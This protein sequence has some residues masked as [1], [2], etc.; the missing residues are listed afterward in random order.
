MGKG[1]HS[2]GYVSLHRSIL[3]WGWYQ[4]ANTCRL[5]IHLLLTAEYQDRSVH[6]RTI[7]RGQRLCSVETLAVELGLSNRQTR[8][9]LEHLKST[10]EVTSR[11]SPQG[12]VITVKNYVDYQTP[13]ND[14][15]NDRQTTDKR[16]VKQTTNDRQTTDKPTSNKEI[17]NKDIPPISPKGD[18]GVFE[19]Y[20]GEDAAL[21]EAL[22]AF[23][24]MRAKIKKPMTD[25]AR[26]RLTQ[27]LDRLAE[28]CP[29]LD[30]VD[31]LEEAVLHC[32]QSVY[33]PKEKAGQA[34]EKNDYAGYV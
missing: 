16:K 21:L 3:R 14:L 32:W 5:F 17:I 25:V 6:G 8:T 28:E 34:K 19:K 29:D 2:A 33:P 9:A 7:K 30:R 18:V 22:K 4:N 15:T 24:Q 31:T 27:K 20:S 10:G 13:T 26:R 11:S 1:D 12:T 23:E